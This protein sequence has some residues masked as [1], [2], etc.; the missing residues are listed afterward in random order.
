M[1][2][3]VFE[4]VNDTWKVEFI[5]KS[6]KLDLTMKQFVNLINE[7]QEREIT[8]AYFNKK[9]LDDL[10]ILSK[11]L[12]VVFKDYDK[13]N[14]REEMSELSKK[15]NKL[16]VQHV[17]RKVKKAL[18]NTK[19]KVT[20]ISLAAIMMTNCM[21]F[22]NLIKQKADSIIKQGTTTLSNY[23]DK[24]PEGT[25]NEKQEENSNVNEDKIMQYFDKYCK[26]FDIN[27]EIKNKLYQENVENFKIGDTIES[28]IIDIIYSYYE[29]N[30]YEK[31]PIQYNNY[32][33]EEQE[34]C[35]IK[36]ALIDDIADTETICTML[37]IHR[38]ETDFG[39]SEYCRNYNN[40]GG[41]YGTN[42]NNNQ[43]EIK[44]YPNLDAAA[45]DFVNVF[46]RIEEKCKDL[47]TYSPNNTLEYNMNSLYC[48]EKIDPNGP[49][50]YEVIASLKEDIKSEY[51]NE[52]NNT[53]D[54]NGKV[55]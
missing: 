46:T 24:A 8:D 17:T 42:P 16:L 22:N 20:A 32:T 49:E 15:I 9:S 23:D 39:N 45:I 21:S 18:S 43:Y 3:I 29:T 38:L 37:A 34:E 11:D 6:E 26:I 47:P 55:Y 52:I 41:V 48:T 25:Y 36:Y 51:E 27:D 7:L 12:Q 44:K 35:I 5:N 10:I 54:T 14:H 19:V 4:L 13:V 40:L 53:T 30:L 28:E 33:N 1:N 50:W 31:V 2:T